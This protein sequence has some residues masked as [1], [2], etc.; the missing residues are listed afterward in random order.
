[1]PGRMASEAVH[2]VQSP[3]WEIYT[4]VSLVLVQGQARVGTLRSKCAAWGSNA[5]FRALA[6]ILNLTG[7]ATGWHRLPESGLLW[8][9]CS[10]GNRLQMQVQEQEQEGPGS[11]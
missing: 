10:L 4:S 8:P 11:N 2:R 3:C 5:R 1:M 9:V 6:P 7:H